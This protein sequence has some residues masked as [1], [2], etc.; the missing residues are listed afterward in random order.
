MERN[1]SK[2]GITF[3]RV[4]IDALLNSTEENDVVELVTVEKQG[5]LAAGVKCVILEEPGKDKF[6]EEGVL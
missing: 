6:F 3:T 5:R 2:H 4:W 1:A